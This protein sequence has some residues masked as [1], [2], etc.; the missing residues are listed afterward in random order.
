MKTYHDATVEGWKRIA[1]VEW[2]GDPDW[3]RFGD[4]IPADE[5]P[6]DFDAWK[7]YDKFAHLDCSVIIMSRN[8]I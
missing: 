3:T 5:L 8:G 7:P 6:D 4:E 2:D 1:V